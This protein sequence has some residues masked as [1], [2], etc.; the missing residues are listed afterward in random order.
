[1]T[2]DAFKVAAIVSQDSEVM[3]FVAL[4]VVVSLDDLRDI[5]KLG[6]EKSDIPHKLCNDNLRAASV[7][8]CGKPLRILI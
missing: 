7:Y 4:R 2:P 8:C 1:M 3:R 5:G 6:G